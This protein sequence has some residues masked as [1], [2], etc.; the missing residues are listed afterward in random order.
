MRRY[1]HKAKNWWWRVLSLSIGS[2]LPLPPLSIL[3][4]EPLLGVSSA[5]LDFLVLFPEAACVCLQ[6]LS[7]WTLSTVSSPFHTLKKTGLG[8]ELVLPATLPAEI[9]GTRNSLDSQCHP[10]IWSFLK[11]KLENMLENPVPCQDWLKAGKAENK[12]TQNDPCHFPQ[13]TFP[14]WSEGAS[15]ILGPSNQRAGWVKVIG[16]F[17]D[18][19]GPGIPPK[20]LRY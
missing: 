16:D 15:V 14:P 5:A 4:P 9:W 2:L 1:R 6:P 18:S 3:D 8:E 11:I 17:I 12:I 10:E 19:I 20:D 7:L 13:I